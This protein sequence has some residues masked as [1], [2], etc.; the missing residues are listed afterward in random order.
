MRVCPVHGTSERMGREH[1]AQLH[2]PL[3]LPSMLPRSST[4]CMWAGCRLMPPVMRRA[5]CGMREAGLSERTSRPKHQSR[6]CPRR[7]RR[8]NRMCV[9]PDSHAAASAQRRCP[10][11]VDH[12]PSRA[13]NDGRQV[14]AVSVRDGWAWKS[15]EEA[16]DPSSLRVPAGL[17]PSACA[18]AGCQIVPIR[19]PGG[20]CQRRASE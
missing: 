10:A 17:L 9:S 5:E 19:R 14:G 8:Q 4:F 20:M 6:G 18:L 13:A 11:A 1:V 2:V 3:P 16:S 12:V 15:F 7:S